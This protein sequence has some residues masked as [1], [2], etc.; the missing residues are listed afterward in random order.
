M[1]S[2]TTEGEQGQAEAS[3]WA[4]GPCCWAGLSTWLAVQGSEL[5]GRCGLPVTRRGDPQ[6]AWLC[7]LEPELLTGPRG[8]GDGGSDLPLIHLS[9]RPSLHVPTCPSIYPASQ[10]GD[11]A[12]WQSGLVPWALGSVPSTANTRHFPTH[13]FTSDASVHLLPHPSP[14][15]YASVHLCTHLSHTCPAPRASSMLSPRFC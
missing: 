13:L 5:P 9:T 15:V 7:G 14:T 4:S 10:A 1:Q 2:C 12:Q 11:G 6:R 3:P 8:A